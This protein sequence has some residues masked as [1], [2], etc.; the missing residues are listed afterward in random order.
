MAQLRAAWPVGSMADDVM[1]RIRESSPRPRGRRRLVLGLSLSGVAAA[2]FLAWLAVVNQPKTLLAAVEEGLKRAQ[3]AHVTTTAWDD[4]DAPHSF[5]I[6]YRRG[7]GLRVDVPGQ[8]I[9]EDGKT[10]WSWSTGPGAAEPIVLRQRSPGFFTTGLLSKLALPD[11]RGDWARFRTPEL[12]R[13]VDG[14]AC[15]AYRLSLADL[16]EMPRGARAADGQEHRALILAE[17]D[18]RIALITL[19][20]RPAGGDW[21]R[22]RAIHIEYDVPVA[23]EKVAARFP[24]GARIVDCDQAFNSLFPLEKALHKVELG[25]LI[26]AVHDVQ[27]L[28]DREGMYVISSV[29][30]TPEFLKQYPPRRRFINPEITM[31]DVAF[32]PMTNRMWS[33]KYDI[34]GLGVANREGIEY[35]WWVIVPRRFFEMKEGKRVYQP[36]RDVSVIPGEPARLDDVPN[37]ARIP[38]AATYWDEKHRDSRGVQQEVST[39]AVVPLLPDRGPTTWE[40]IAARARRDLLVMGCGSAGG[41]YGVAAD[42]KPDGPSGRGISSLAPDAISDAQFVA[43]VRRG[44]DDLR[45]YDEV[46]TGYV[47]GFENMLPPMGEATP[48]R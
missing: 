41:L 47:P 43:A 31:L 42:T 16:E 25:G 32:Q 29:R 23:A 15:R 9:V 5:D 8:V 36:E 34:I 37:A 2:V 20:R 13:A 35:R 38:L 30:G 26:L 4:H 10:Q 44:L 1:A 28:K 39:W 3:S 11:I 46:R 14:R 40:D 22:E 7:E 21:K 17:A 33:S 48:K 12:D 24:A 45:A 27:P 6:W 18:E 19:E